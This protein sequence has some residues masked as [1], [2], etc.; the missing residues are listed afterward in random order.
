MEN[1]NELLENTAMDV[2]YDYGVNEMDSVAD[3]NV[4]KSSGM[5]PVL[6]F[7][8]GALTGLAVGFVFRKVRTIIKNRKARV[9]E[10]MAAMEKE[11]KTEG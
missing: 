1:N 8:L 10:E 9:A 11:E 5:S 6:S 7:G 2:T 3:T 4:G